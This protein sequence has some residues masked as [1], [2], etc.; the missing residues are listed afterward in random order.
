MTD[1]WFVWSDDYEPIRI[2]YEDNN[3]ISALHRRHWEHIDVDNPY[4]NERNRIEAFFFPLTHTPRI[5]KT[6]SD[7]TFYILI[8]SFHTRK[9]ED[10]E[11]VD[12]TIP[13]YFKCVGT[14][15]RH[16]PPV[17]YQGWPPLT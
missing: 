5:R 2:V 17:R 8:R 6:R 16:L 4:T 1:F 14:K 12:D 9:L 11:I 3:I 7:L 13:E 15:D 10:Y